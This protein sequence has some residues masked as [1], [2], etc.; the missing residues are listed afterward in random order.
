MSNLNATIPALIF[1]TFFSCITINSGNNKLIGY[2]LTSPDVSIILPDILKEVSGVTYLGSNSFACIQDENGILFIYNTLKNKLEKQYTFN[3]D[4]DYEGIARVNKTIY[5]LRSDGALFEISDYESKDFTLDVYFTKIPSNNN[6]GLCYDP[7]NKRLLIACKGK[8]NKGSDDRREIYGFDLKTK[9]L[10]KE[11]VFDFDL[12][13]IKQFA[14][15]N[16]IDLPVRKKKKGKITEPVIK[17][18]TSAICIHPLTKRLYLIS[19]S[20]HLLFIFNANGTIEYIELLNPYIFNNSEGIS[21]FEN[22]DMLIANEGHGKSPTLLRFN[23][24][25][26]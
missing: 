9:T 17:F 6:E 16:E 1:L 5:V 25:K 20:D 10:T 26:E 24:R 15:D 22:G 8:S 19:S 23:F 7:D 2:N 4:G 12:N 14:L 3:I 11:P 18:E 13:V 21:F